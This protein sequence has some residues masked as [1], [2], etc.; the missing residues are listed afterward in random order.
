VISAWKKKDYDARKRDQG[1]E[2]E[3]KPVASASLVVIN[4]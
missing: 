3:I 2:Q 1:K 4:Q